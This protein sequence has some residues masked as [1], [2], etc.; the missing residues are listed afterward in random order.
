VSAKV[1][2]GSLVEPDGTVFERFEI[3][4]EEDWWRAEAPVTEGRRLSAPPSCEG[5]EK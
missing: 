3:E 4:R 5:I 1:V 2:A